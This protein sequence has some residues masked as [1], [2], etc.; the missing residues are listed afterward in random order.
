MT[1]GRSLAAVVYVL[2]ALAWAGAMVLSRGLIC[3]GG[4]T[5][6]E[7]DRMDTSVVLA[8]VGLAIAAAALF[9]SVLRPRFGLVLLWCHALLWT[10][11][12][13]LFWEVPDAAWGFV[14][15][16]VLAAAAGFVAVGGHKIDLDHDRNDRRGSR[17]HH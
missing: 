8:F 2:A 7:V 17:P 6:S 16:A 12:L 5:A 9:G 4:C 15:A 3:D 11:N 14:P 1:F 10:I 13:A